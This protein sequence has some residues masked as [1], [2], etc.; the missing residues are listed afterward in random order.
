MDVL[1]STDITPAMLVSINAPERRAGEVEWSNAAW[2]AGSIVTRTATQRVYKAAFPVPAGGVPPEE[3]IAVAQLPYWVDIGPMNRQAMFDK[4]VKSQTVGP[5]GNLVVV[6]KP[7]PITDIWLG[8]LDNVTAARVE[9][10]DKTGGSIIYDQRRE[11]VGKVTTAWDWCFAPFNFERDARF[12]GIPAY[13]NCEVTITLEAVS[14]ALIGMAAIGK[15]ENLGKTEWDVNASFQRYT[16]RQS[17]QSWGPTQQGGEITKDVS[18][19]IFVRPDDAPRVDR[20][21]KSAMNRLAVYVPTGHARF[22]GI[23]IF[24]EMISAEMG[25]PGPNYVPFDITVR[26]FL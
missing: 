8:N 5:A 15:N 19:R 10:R 13:R 3:N 16:P 9:V 11:Q 20:F 4:Q 17:S 14:P 24:G 25:Y 6:L 18:Y 1:L 23:R 2:P 22:A 26:E 7:G 21:A 12:T